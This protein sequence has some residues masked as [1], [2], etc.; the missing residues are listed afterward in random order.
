[1]AIRAFQPTD[2]DYRVLVDPVTLH[3][4]LDK[5]A[6]LRCDDRAASA[7]A[8]LTGTPYL[9]ALDAEREREDLLQDAGI[10]HSLSPVDGYFMTADLCPSSHKDFNKDFF[11]TLEHAGVSPFAYSTYSLDGTETKTVQYL[12]GSTVHFAFVF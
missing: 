7:Q 3:T 6:A 12:G 10:V 11:A 5:L 4:H 8:L 9:R 1:M 2:F